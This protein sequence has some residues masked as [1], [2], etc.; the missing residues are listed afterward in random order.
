MRRSAPC[1]AVHPQRA[2]A[3]PRSGPGPRHRGYLPPLELLGVLLEVLEAALHEEGLLGE[4]VVGALGERLECLEGLRQRHEGAR[5]TGERLRDEHVLREEAL[6]APGPVDR[7]L[8]LLAE[9]V[10]AE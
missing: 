4:V 9:L 10:D 7:D 6:D 5:L 2:R 1:R 3:G 8:V